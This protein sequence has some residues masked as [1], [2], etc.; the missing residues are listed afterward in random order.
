MAGVKVVTDSAQDFDPA[1]LESLGV[2]VVPLTVHFGDES[3]RDGFDMRGRA[4]YEKLRTSPHHPRTSQPSPGTFQEVFERLTGDGSSVVTITLSA[5]LS[6]TYQAA[7]LAKEALPDRQ[8]SVID[9]KA[10]SGGYGIMAILAAEM[11]KEGRAFEEIVAKVRKMVDS[12]VTVFS[13]DTLDYLAKNGRIGKAAHFLG[14]I[15]NMKPILSLDKEGYVTAIERVRGK[16][17]VIPRMVEIAR[18]RLPSGEKIIAC[19]SHADAPEEA[20]KLK[21][22]VTSTFPV[23]RLFETEIG[24]IIGTHTGPGTLAVCIVPASVIG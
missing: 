23:E 13:V 11:A 24:S 3:Y 10:A 12:L 18:E 5:A 9:S 22:M 20:R 8:I 21:E 7:V 2:T 4:F 15:L 14:T 1:F 6:G 19:V 17:K 16:G